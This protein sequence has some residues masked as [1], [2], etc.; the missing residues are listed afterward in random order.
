MSV[1]ESSHKSILPFSKDPMYP[2][3][4]STE[5]PTVDIP[6]GLEQTLGMCTDFYFNRG[7]VRR[8]FCLCQWATICR[9]VIRI[10]GWG[11]ILKR[12]HRFLCLRSCSV[13]IH[14]SFHVRG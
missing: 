6:S 8:V 13:D 11:F 4:N 7:D 3:V 10:R 5:T 1:H 14:G 9:C 12:I 2:L